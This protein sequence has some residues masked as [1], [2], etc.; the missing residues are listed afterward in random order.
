M[1]ARFIRSKT[2]NQKFQT[3]FFFN[4]GNCFLNFFCSGSS[5]ECKGFNMIYHS[6]QSDEYLWYVILGGKQRKTTTDP[7]KFHPIFNRRNN[8][9]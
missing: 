3:G 4:N 7:N 5:Q 6:T 8:K 2:K 1:L 9:A